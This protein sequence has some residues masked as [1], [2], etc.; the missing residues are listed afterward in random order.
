MQIKKIL[1]SL[2]NSYQKLVRANESFAG[3]EIDSDKFQTLIDQ[4]SLIIEDTDLLTAELIKEINHVYLDN[5]FSCKNI[6]E[7]VRALQILAPELVNEC[8]ALKT[9]LHALVESDARVEEKL[10]NLKDSLKNEINKIR[11]SSRVIKGY[12]QADPM[13]SCFIDKIK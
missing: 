8:E 3:R 10:T 12:K 1:L 9:S 2:A 5:S 11:K 4:R 6:P 13:G 7:A